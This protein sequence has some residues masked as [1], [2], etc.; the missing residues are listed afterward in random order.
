MKVIAEIGSNV[1]SL[2]DCI[3]SIKMAKQFDADAVKFQ[4]FTSEDMFGVRGICKNLLDKDYIPKL[5]EI[6]DECGIEFMC[7]VFNPTTLKWLLPYVKTIKIA[8]SDMEH[9]ELLDV[10]LES[11]KEIY[12]STGAHSQDE[13]SS[14]LEHIGD[15][16]KVTL[17]YCQAEYPTYRTDFRKLAMP[18]F[19]KYPRIGLSDHSKEIYVTPLMAKMYSMVALEKHVNFCGY[20]DTPD[21][22]H[23]LSANE[24]DMMIRAIKGE[25]PTSF[26]SVGDE[27][28]RLRHNRRLIVTKEIKAGDRFIYN[29]NFGAYRSMRDNVD[30]ISPIFYDKVDQMYAKRNLSIGDAITSKD[31]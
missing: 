17:F 7:T 3:H 2:E 5:K 6:A 8:S 18:P 22:P 11:G 9:I 20:T 31:Y 4:C 14:I 30:G 16:K 25:Q 24:F 21:A 15:T 23:S 29:D 19:S 27:S 1:K 26:L 12:L 28:M 10:A 13:I